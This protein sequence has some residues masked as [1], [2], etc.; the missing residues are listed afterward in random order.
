MSQSLTRAQSIALG[1][2]VLLAVVLGAFG[3]VSVGSKQGLWADTFEVRVGFPDAHDIQPG[4]AVRVRGVDA[5]QVTGVDYPAT[6]E[7]GAAVTV[8]LRLDARFRDRL[9]ADASAQVHSTGLLGAKVIAVTPGTP[10]AGPLTTGELRP[11]TAPDLAQAAAK[12]G[13]AADEAGMILRDVRAGK[14]TAGKIVSDDDLY[15]D[16]KGLVADSR[17]QVQKL[18]TFVQDGR[19]TMKSLRANSDAI[20]GLPIIRSYVPE[21]VTG[22]LTRSELR[23][24]AHTYTAADVFEPGSAVLSDAGKEHM[25]SEA[26]WLKTVENDDADVVVAA[27]TDP[28]DKSIDPAAARELTQKRA[29]AVVKF[30]KA[31][32]AHRLGW[33][34]RRKVTAVG[35]GAGPLPNADKGAPAAAV[36][37]LLFSPP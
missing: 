12:I 4:T 8:R 37:V 21:D 24:V 33:W 6:D 7:P 5:G 3:L 9:Y 11:T 20:K 19:D 14:G 27:C 17:G 30:L 32:G 15:R 35:L 31:D 34:T 10:A 18:D 36:Q 2:V 16:L 26:K 23:R 28:A 22:L 29:E 1:A 25:L 13:A